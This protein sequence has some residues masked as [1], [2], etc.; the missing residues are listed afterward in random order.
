MKG[1]VWCLFR[2]GLGGFVQFIACSCRLGLQ[3]TQLMLCFWQKVPLLKT[4]CSKTYLYLFVIFIHFPYFFIAKF[5]LCPRVR[6]CRS[7]IGQFFL[8]LW[9]T[10]LSLRSGEGTRWECHQPPEWS[11]DRRALRHVATTNCSVHCLFQS[12]MQ[13][14]YNVVQTL[15]HQSNAILPRKKLRQPVGHILAS[16]HITARRQ[17]H[18]VIILI[19][20]VYSCSCSVSLVF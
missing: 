20:F 14:L 19:H 8:C 16:F 6:H 1:W 17:T 11:A 12:K 18:E 10:E 15:L 7:C 3:I 2:L 5:R 13:R 9:A 4:A